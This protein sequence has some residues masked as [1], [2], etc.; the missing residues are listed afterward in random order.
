MVQRLW[1]LWDQWVLWAVA[2]NPQVHGILGPDLPDGT[3]PWPSLATGH[4]VAG[5]WIAR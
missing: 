3:A 1:N 5:L 2:Y 4:S